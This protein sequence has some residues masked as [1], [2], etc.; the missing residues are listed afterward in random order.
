MREK[1]G[2][3]GECR[4]CVIR[5][6]GKISA[7][8]DEEMSDARI[9]GPRAMSKQKDDLIERQADKKGEA[10]REERMPRVIAMQSRH[11]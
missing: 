2:R 8:I 7:T 4:R 3:D 10:C 11:H 5:R 1:S 6:E 9:I